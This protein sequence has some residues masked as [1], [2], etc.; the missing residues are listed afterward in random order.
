MMGKASAKIDIL[1]TET[2]VN[3]YI[4]SANGNNNKNQLASGN[5]LL[6]SITEILIK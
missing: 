2:N 4:I 3:S 6:M 1:Q 5:I